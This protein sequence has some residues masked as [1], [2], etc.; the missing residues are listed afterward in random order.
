[1]PNYKRLMDEYDDQLEEWFSTG[2]IN[3]EVREHLRSGAN[4]VFEAL[5]AASTKDEIMEDIGKRFQSDGYHT[6]VNHLKKIVDNR[7]RHRKTDGK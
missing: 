3:E 2:H 4:R 5:L 7:E 6:V 1:M